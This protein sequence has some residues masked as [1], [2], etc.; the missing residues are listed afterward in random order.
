MMSGPAK[1]IKNEEEVVPIIRRFAHAIDDEDYAQLFSL[2]P[3]TGF[4]ED[5][6]RYDARRAEGDPTVSMH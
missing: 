3:E 1:L 6:Q 5:V 2:Y 4:E